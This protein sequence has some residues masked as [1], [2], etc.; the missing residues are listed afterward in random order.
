MNQDN[1]A[2][3]SGTGTLGGLSA[4]EIACLEWVSLG[5]ASKEIARK[6]DVSPH[7]VDARLKAACGKLGTKSR[8]VAAKLLTDARSSDALPKENPVDTNLVYEILD[9]PG[10]TL[11]G[12]KGPSAG[13]GDGPDDLE[14]GNSRKLESQRDSGTER[15]WLEPSHPIARFLGGENRLSIWQRVA[16]VM[17]I[18]MG[19][20]LTFG[21]LLNGFAGV[22]QL[23]S[24]P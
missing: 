9:L 5:L 4:G 10:G 17:G 6:L 14:P 15:S 23:L 19:A 24:S 7:T 16:I 13:E 3:V 22:S 11:H 20:G 1:P 2:Q 21:V 18:A 12:D 8:F